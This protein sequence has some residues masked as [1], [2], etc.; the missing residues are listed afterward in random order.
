MAYRIAPIELENHGIG[1]HA[2]EVLGI[3]LAAR[4]HGPADRTPDPLLV[5]GHQPAIA[6]PYLRK[7]VFRHHSS[8]TYVDARQKHSGMTIRN[9]RLPRSVLTHA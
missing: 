3:A 4:L 9:N 7:P 6:F 8:T 5:K 1:D 2:R